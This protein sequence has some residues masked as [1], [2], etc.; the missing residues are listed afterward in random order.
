MGGN[1]NERSVVG[2]AAVAALYSSSSSN[3]FLEYLAMMVSMT[4]GW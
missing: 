1:E 2:F 3:A 4:E